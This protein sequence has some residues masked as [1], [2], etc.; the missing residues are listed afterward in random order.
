MIIRFDKYLFFN[1]DEI[2]TRCDILKKYKIK[3]NSYAGK[4]LMRIYD[5][6]FGNA[7]NINKEFKRYYKREFGTCEQYLIC[8]FNMSKD[9]AKK[10][11]ENKKYYVNLEWKGEEIGYTFSFDDDLRKQFWDFV[12]GIKYEN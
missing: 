4:V 12:G 6:Y 9:L 7:I 3:R 2:I 8:R 1:K 5:Y 10:I 11:S